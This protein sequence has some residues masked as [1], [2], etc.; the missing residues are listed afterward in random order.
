MNM[1]KILLSI[2]A[3]GFLTGSVAQVEKGNLLIKNGTVL[4]ITKGVLEST[5]VLVKDGKITQIGK[6]LVAP[7]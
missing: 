4:T 7:L 1:K 2:I 3:V 6:G 5:D